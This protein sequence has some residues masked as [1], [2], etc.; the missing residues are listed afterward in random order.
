VRQ[1]FRKATVACVAALVLLPAC[2]DD[3]DSGTGAT[4]SGPPPSST[5]STTAAATTSFAPTTTTA[6][7]RTE[8]AL[9]V[10]PFPDAEVRFDDPIEVATSFAVDLVGFVDPVVGEFRE[11]DSRSGEI[12]IRARESGPATTVLVRQ[13]GPESSWWVI[14]S[15]A[16][17]IEVTEPIAQSAVDD[18]LQMA[19]RS[20][21]FE[22]NIAVDV[23]ADG[24]TERIGSGFVTGGSGPD[25]GP[26]AGSMRFTSPQGG[27]GSVIFF[28]RS[29]EDGQV[30]E[31]TTVRVGFI[32]GD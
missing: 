8:Q 30:W 20:R 23:V 10:W 15:I 14:G 3:S 2:G 24:S 29:M 9:V 18:P 26:F 17:N 28:I 12:E 6:L 16:T 7:S 22:G 21:A 11:G 5:T 13:F 25:F 27:W 1:P 4:T 19:G 31:A 32:G